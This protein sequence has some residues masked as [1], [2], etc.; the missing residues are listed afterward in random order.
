MGWLSLPSLSQLQNTF[1]DVGL[2]INLVLQCFSTVVIDKAQSQRKTFQPH[3]GAWRCLGVRTR[4]WPLLATSK[5]HVQLASLG[6]GSQPVVLQHKLVPLNLTS[7]ERVMGLQSTSRIL[8]Q[9]WLAH[10]NHCWA[11]VQL[12]MTP[13]QFDLVIR[14]L[15]A[16]GAPKDSQH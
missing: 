11:T 14:R 5:R 8:Q 16:I 2:F 1:Y 13:V 9:F 15:I 10:I 12:A 4:P 3:A 6:W 7:D